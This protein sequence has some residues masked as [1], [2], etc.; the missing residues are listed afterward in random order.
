MNNLTTI[1]IFGEQLSFSAGHFTIFSPTERERLHGHNYDVSATIVTEVLEHGVAF[2]Y[3]IYREKIKALCQEINIYFLLP[4]E[5]QLLRIEEK[6]KLY[7]VYFNGEEIPLLK[8]DTIILPIKNISLEEMSRWFLE[9]LTE[10][11]E[12]I[13]KYRIHALTVTVSSGHGRSASARM[14]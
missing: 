10:D 1:K 9:R 11:K 2:N 4:G 6:E 5:S 3:E 8:S 13:S 12:S 14:L 7:H